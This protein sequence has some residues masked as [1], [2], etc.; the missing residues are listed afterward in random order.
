M[1]CVT[2]S[3]D[4][5]CD[6]Y[7]PQL[8]G[9]TTSSQLTQA[10]ITNAPIIIQMRGGMNFEDSP[11]KWTQMEKDYEKSMNKPSE[12]APMPMITGTY[13]PGQEVI[14][15]KNQDN[16]AEMQAVICPLVWK[17]IEKVYYFKVICVIDNSFSMNTRIKQRHSESPNTRWD[18]L[19]MNVSML[20]KLTS[21]IGCAVSF[22]FIN[23]VMI[24]GVMRDQVDNVTDISQLRDFLNNGPHGVTPMCRSLLNIEKDV[25]AT[26][27][28]TFIIIMTD[29]E[30][31]DSCPLS[32]NL[33]V[34]G[35]AGF[36]RCVQRIV[37]CRDHV[38]V[39]ILAC[40]DNEKEIEFMN[41]IDSDKTTTKF[42]RQTFLPEKEIGYKCPITYIL[43]KGH[44]PAIPYFRKNGHLVGS[45]VDVIDDFYSEGREISYTISKRFGQEEAR[46][47]TY[48]FETHVARFL[49]GAFIEWLDEADGH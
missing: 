30:P 29:G 23:P 40:T 43:P 5:S 10:S 20:C 16:F 39:N 11:D 18:E 13:K 33:S 25:R 22:N 27:T 35:G 42:V 9:L 46:K 19:K 32:G 12:D 15:E 1:G 21:G 36:K 47:M 38:Y 3:P 8:Q 7:Q 24:D 4:V 28:P 34:Y 45:H 44:T 17:E 41:G 26:S 37:S 14:L 2:S 48:N 6:Q 49:L 31:S